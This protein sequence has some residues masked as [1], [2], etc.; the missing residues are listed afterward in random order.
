M[1][2]A[3][4]LSMLGVL[5]L[6]GCAPPASNAQSHASAAQIAACRHSADQAVLIQNPNVVYQSDAYVSGTQ[7]A[8][9]SGAGASNLT[10]GLPQ[11]YTREEYYENCLNGI[12]PAPEAFPPAQANAPPPEPSVT[13]SPL[14]P[15]ASPASLTSPPASNLA[16]PPANLTSPP[17]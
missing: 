13:S 3:I 14:S 15:Q 5:A 11:R 9:F 2:A 1:K 12:G 7:S 6:A 17:P 16:A 4:A 10:G 8:P